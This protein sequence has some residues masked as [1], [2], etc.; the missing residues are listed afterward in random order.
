[1]GI[2]P[3]HLKVS[4]AQHDSGLPANVYVTELMG[5]ETLVLLE[6]EGNRVVAR[7]AGDFRS[8]VGSTVYLNFQVE[9]AHFFDS[10]SG[11]RIC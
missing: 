5:N 4:Q 8:D 3:D 11:L 7:A 10:Q 9:H 6:I 1:M 2:R